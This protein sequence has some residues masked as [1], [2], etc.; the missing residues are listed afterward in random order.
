MTRI[1]SII[2]PIDPY[3]DWRNYTD[4]EWP[5]GLIIGLFLLAFLT[6]KFLKKRNY[7]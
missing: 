7:K 6:F 1:K 5:L 4:V 3:F 2:S